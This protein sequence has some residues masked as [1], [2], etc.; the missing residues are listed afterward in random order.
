MGFFRSLCR[1]DEDFFLNGI[2]DDKVFVAPLVNV[3]DD[4]QYILFVAL[5]LLC[6]PILVV[7]V[8]GDSDETLSSHDKIDS[9]CGILFVTLDV[10]F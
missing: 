8:I 3:C 6:K 9:D 7:L 4:I 1:N 2:E 5:S 10:T